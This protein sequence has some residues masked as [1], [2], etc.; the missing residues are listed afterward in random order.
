MTEE[1]PSW[2]QETFQEFKSYCRYAVLI[3]GT[4]M[5]SG[6]NTT[7]ASLFTSQ[8]A[9]PWGLLNADCNPHSLLQSVG[10]QYG[11][12]VVA[13]LDSMNLTSTLQGIND[14][15]ECPAQFGKLTFSLTLG[16]VAKAFAVVP[17]FV[18]IDRFGPRRIAV[19]GGTLNV[20]GYVLLLALCFTGGPGGVLSTIVAFVFSETGAGLVFAGVHGVVWCEE[21]ARKRIFIMAALAYN[22]QG[23]MALKAQDY[24]KS[25]VLSGPPQLQYFLYYPIL[26]LVALAIVGKLTPT[27]QAYMEAKLEY[28]DDD[29]EWDFDKGTIQR[30]RTFYRET[31]N[32]LK[33][34]RMRNLMLTATVVCTT[35]WAIVYN[36][37][38]PVYIYDFLVPSLVQSMMGGTLQDDLELPTTFAHSLTLVM[39]L[40]GVVTV[41]G[42]E[43]IAA[44][45][46]ME[47]FVAMLTV[48]QIIA[49]CA[50]DSPIYYI[51]LFVVG[52]CAGISLGASWIMVAEHMF[53]YSPPNAWAK[54]VC[55]VNLRV[56][57]VSWVLMNIFIELGMIVGLPKMFSWMTILSSIVGA[58]YTAMCFYQGVPSYSLMEKKLCELYSCRSMPEILY[59][60]GLSEFKKVGAENEEFPK[61]PEFNDATMA[62][63]GGDP[64]TEMKRLNKHREEIEHWQVMRN[65]L[66]SSDPSV[67][68]EIVL[69]I[70]TDRFQ[71]LLMSRTIEDIVAM[72]KIGFV[73][74]KN[75]TISF[76][77]SNG[78]FSITPQYIYAGKTPSDT[79]GFAI[80]PQLWY[81][82]GKFEPEQSMMNA[83]EKYSIANDED[84]SSVAVDQYGS[85]NRFGGGELSSQAAVFQREKDLLRSLSAREYS[86]DLAK[87]LRKGDYATLRSWLLT[88]DIASMKEA[89]WDM[90]RWDAWLDLPKNARKSENKQPNKRGNSVKV[91][92][93]RANLEE[94]WNQM[95]PLSELVR[96][97]QERPELKP[98]VAERMTQDL[99]RAQEAMK[100]GESVADE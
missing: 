82:F 16:S 96:V 92:N 32:V 76:R 27:K 43:Q 54:V 77:M 87:I 68:Q 95:M 97:M 14:P 83:L 61:E 52:I 88:K 58:I 33:L 60:T 84:K 31:T 10:D 19:I 42:G 59:L 9:F 65:L 51:Q 50:I 8:W 25:A 93:P 40:T 56:A 49:A 53:H 81:Q 47:K 57:C 4:A 70:R 20:L 35:S 66:T 23:Y 90:M 79:G 55:I 38:A 75:S 85:F 39:M 24:I 74:D 71:E 89:V 2:F 22:L 11:A 62:A 13:M 64:M 78:G 100:E 18:F 15:L 98:V 17:T 91:R 21:A 99:I 29:G 80:T 26:L 94:L 1:Q 5:L 41:L 6:F 34:S 72:Q 3:L 48:V 67:Q 36:C 73:W 63:S 30:L 69:S 86:K 46:K 28:T 45:V 44:K 12:P 7:G 37:F